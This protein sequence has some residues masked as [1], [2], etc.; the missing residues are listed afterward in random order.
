MDAISEI[1]KGIDIKDLA[2]RLGTD[3]TTTKKAATAAIPALLSGLQSNSSNATGQASLLSAL[4]QHSKAPASLDDIDT[5]DGAKIV[6]HALGKGKAAPKGLAG[7]DPKMISNLL[8]M[9]APMVMSWLSGQVLGGGAKKPAAGGGGNDLLGGL[10]GGVMGNVLGGGGS[11]GPDLG[12]LL[13]NVLGGAL[14]GN[15]APKATPA[16]RTTT[17]RTTAAKTTSTAR[18]TTARTTAAKTTA[19][20]KAPAKKP[21]AAPQEPASG[22]GDLLGGLLGKILGG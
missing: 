2:G 15:A 9:L 14:G 21:A 22:G 20:K 5:E 13:G 16:A 6:N 1:L 3:T 17:T 4:T 8:P 18:T 11:G 10:V 7:F 12:G 19:A